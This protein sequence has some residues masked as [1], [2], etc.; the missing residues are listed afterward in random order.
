MEALDFGTMEFC[1][2]LEVSLLRHG[3]YGPYSL[4]SFM[5]EGCLFDS[6]KLFA[7]DLKDSKKSLLRISVYSFQKHTEQARAVQSLNSTFQGDFIL[8]LTYSHLSL[9]LTATSYHGVKLGTQL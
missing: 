7:M 6:S 1:W 3:V 5:L 4:A 8:T 2:D 9:T